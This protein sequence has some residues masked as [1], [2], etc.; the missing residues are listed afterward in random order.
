[1]D[2]LIGLTDSTALWAMLN[3]RTG[4]RLVANSAQRLLLLI[5]RDWV[6]DY[7]LEDTGE[8]VTCE[9]GHPACSIE[10]F[11]RRCSDDTL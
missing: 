2:I 6:T 3:R 9:H 11:N 5:D 1:V 8:A 10:G 7:R 4:A